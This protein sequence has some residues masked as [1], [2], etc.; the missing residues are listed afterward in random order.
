LFCLGNYNKERESSMPT[1]KAQCQQGRLCWRI[2]RRGQGTRGSRVILYLG[3]DI[4]ERED[5]WRFVLRNDLISL[6]IDNRLY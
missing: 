1:S 5:L 3:K 6:S 4:V 2:D